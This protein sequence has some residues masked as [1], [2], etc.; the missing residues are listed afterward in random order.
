MDEL[1]YVLWTYC[2]T[3]RRS[4][5]E[6]PFSMTY[7]SKAI[8][9]FEAGFPTLKT[10][11]FQVDK[12]DLLHAMSL[13]L[14]DERREVAMVKMA[15]YQQKLRQGYDKRVKA[16]PLE[17]ANMVLRKVVGTM[18]NPSWGKLGPNCEGP[19]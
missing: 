5:E 18:K 12:N 3:P 17:S 9:P 19:Y 7:G 8:I 6:T 11:Q 15:H 14:I 16:R 2:T 10:D 13:E 4:T 1:P